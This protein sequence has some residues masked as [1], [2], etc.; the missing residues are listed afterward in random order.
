MVNRDRDQFEELDQNLKNFRKEYRFGVLEESQLKNDPF[1]QFEFWFLQVKNANSIEPNAMCLSTVNSLGEPTSRI[2]LLKSYSSEGLV[3]FTNYESKKGRDIAG[4]AKVSLLFFW[5]EFERQV[6]ISGLASKLPEKE[7][8]RYFSS[9]PYGSQ[10]ATHVSRQS[11]VISGREFL[12][13]RW[14]AV[15]EQFQD[16]KVTRPHYWGGY[17]VAPN[18][19]EFW[20]GREN[21]LHDRIEYLKQESGWIAQ[22]LSP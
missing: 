13:Q 14:D 18:R 5:P 10:I 9:R 1:E 8:D 3:F 20:Q 22:R 2:V 4:N 15:I 17:I 21:R 12:E 6:K 16:S 11:K 19:F 7:S